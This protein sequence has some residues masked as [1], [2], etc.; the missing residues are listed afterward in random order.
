MCRA[1]QTGPLGNIPS[2]PDRR[3][4]ECA[5]ATRYSLSRR[6]AESGDCMDWLLGLFGRGRLSVTVLIG[7][8]LAQ[9]PVSLHPVPADEVGASP[10]VPAMLEGHMDVGGRIRNVLLKA[11]R[12]R[13][14][15]RLSKSGRAAG[16]DVVA[17]PLF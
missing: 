13:I 14:F 10:R 5:D 4:S 11:G 16:G 6:V 8:T 9:C 15:V 12:Y 2:R 1:E 7:E 3:S 17:A